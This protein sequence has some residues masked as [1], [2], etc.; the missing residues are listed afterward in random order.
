VPLPEQE[1]H[2]EQ[3]GLK[4]TR[5]NGKKCTNTI[6]KIAVNYLFILPSNRFFDKFMPE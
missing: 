1:W 3:F 4:I 6:Q 2:C 5:V